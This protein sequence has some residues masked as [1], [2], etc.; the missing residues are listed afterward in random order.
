[1]FIKSPEG[2]AMFSS[3]SIHK[4]D[5]SG[6]SAGSLILI[7]YIDENYIRGLS[8]K[9]KQKI[10]L[11]E[12]AASNKNIITGNVIKNI[13]VTQE[14]KK[15][16]N[17]KYEDKNITAQTIL[18]DINNDKLINLT[19]VK[20]RTIYFQAKKI[21][22][23]FSLALTLLLLSEFFIIYILIKKMILNKIFLINEFVKNVSKE[24]LDFTKDNDELS[25]LAK[26]FSESI[27]KISLLNKEKESIFE[28]LPD[29]VLNINAEGEII[30]IKNTFSDN[31]KQKIEDFLTKENL[32]LLRKNALE[33]ISSKETKNIEIKNNEK[34]YE[35]RLINIEEDGCLVFIR[36]ITM[37][38]T[39]GDKLR[40][41]NEELEKINKLAVDR[42][43]KMIELKK[44]IK[45][46]NNK[47]NN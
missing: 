13:F 2:I 23:L 25:D 40:E 5:K 30:T 15:Y 26:A 18:R 21:I 42:E 28:Y 24:N 31:K 39:L 1:G 36:D 8:D 43:L 11:D 33:S 3:S 22:L 17:I 27:N 35:A 38:K 19:I 45:R 32:L 47:N 9:T 34:Y 41:K 46:L 37:E 44:E 7:R 14:E 29:T 6:D 4:S 12:Y 16:S 20:E 10:L